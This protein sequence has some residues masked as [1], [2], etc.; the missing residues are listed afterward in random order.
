MQD[1]SRIRD[2]AETGIR[3]LAAS[4][5]GVL[6]AEEELELAKDAKQQRFAQRRHQEATLKLQRDRHNLGVDQFEEDKR[7]QTE[8]SEIDKT[9]REAE[10]AK[11]KA[12]EDLGVEFDKELDAYF[13]DRQKYQ[14]EE[15]PEEKERLRQS[16]LRRGAWLESNSERVKRDFPSHK[17]FIDS[18]EELKAKDAERKQKE[19][20]TDK[21]LQA[22]I[23]G[24]K[25]SKILTDEQKQKILDYIA[26]DP[27]FD[28][29]K[30]LQ[31]EQAKAEKL[32]EKAK[33]SEY[34][35]NNAEM[36]GLTAEEAQSIAQ[37]ILDGNETTEETLELL[38]EELES[39]GLS[40]EE[41]LKRKSEIIN[42]IAGV[43]SAST[44]KLTDTE[45]VRRELEAYK[46][47]PENSL[48]VGN[49][50]N[51][52]TSPSSRT[53]FLQTIRNRLDGKSFEEISKPEF[54]REKEDAASL[55]VQTLM[56]NAQ[57]G[58]I[59][60]RELRSQELLRY[61]LPEI[62]KTIDDLRA[63]GI[64]LGKLT[65]GSEGFFR[66][67]GSVLVP[68]VA[69]LNARLEA[70]VNGFIALRSGAQVTEVE[71]KLYKNIFPNVGDGYELNKAKIEGLI[72][73]SAVALNK[74]LTKTLGKEWGNYAT[75]IDFKPGAVDPIKYTTEEGLTLPETPE[76]DTKTETDDTETPETTETGFD[77]K[78]FIDTAKADQ[79]S[80]E[81]VKKWLE[82]NGHDTSNFDELWGE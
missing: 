54:T 11:N 1:Y 77:I 36:L 18:D 33:L 43:R 63:K 4:L 12:L 10:E 53:V 72:T 13:E 47:Q 16:L 5:R 35:I 22:K 66:F 51:L 6:E 81:D 23:K 15:D 76:T 61:H 41:L 74:L 20:E 27:E 3:S 32:P 9:K 64:D 78:S 49:L 50:A 24:V 28:V 73:E 75:T 7:V 38:Y 71:R 45:R 17:R 8:Q 70:L 2:A 59:V 30:H 79:H 52:I 46:D 21:V 34:V 44:A 80:K 42:A 39:L 31:D 26:I 56:K 55:M 19:Q 25:E 58:D 29:V 67:T 82:D 57:G 37:E 69:A 40:P 65:K 48:A 14:T 60:Q 62:M 68:E